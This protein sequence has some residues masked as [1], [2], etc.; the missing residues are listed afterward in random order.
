ML[1][2][3]LLYVIPAELLVKVINNLVSRALFLGQSQGKRLGY[4]KV[5]G[6]LRRMHLSLDMSR[7]ALSW[8]IGLMISIPHDSRVREPRNYESERKA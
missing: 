8:T 1:S 7:N 2:R 6:S 5:R 4:E 3:T